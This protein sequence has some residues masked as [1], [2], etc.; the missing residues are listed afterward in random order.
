M[1]TVFGELSNQVQHFLRKSSNKSCGF[2][3]FNIFFGLALIN[4]RF[5]FERF[6]RNAR[7][8]MSLR[9]EFSQ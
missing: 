1:N 5:F 9:V 6:R 3:K 2:W 4:A 7:K 8:I